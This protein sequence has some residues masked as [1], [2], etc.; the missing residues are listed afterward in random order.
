MKYENDTRISLHKYIK[1]YS[2]VYSLIVYL[3]VS[4]CI[5]EPQ[6]HLTNL[7]YFLYRKFALKC[8]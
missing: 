2:T 7:N 3:Y 1:L 6:K 4:Q 8:V 5:T